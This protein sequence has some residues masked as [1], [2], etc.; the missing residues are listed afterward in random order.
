MEI[1]EIKTSSR[2]YSGR[3]FNFLNDKYIYIYIYI[4]SVTFNWYK[5]CTYVYF[6][7]AK[8]A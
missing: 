8:L 1:K 2:L 3:S 7:L 5:I 4:K 6:S